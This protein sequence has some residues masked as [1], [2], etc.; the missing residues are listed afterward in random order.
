MKT[1]RESKK[2][3]NLKL[4][5][6]NQEI[7][8]CTFWESTDG[9]SKQYRCGSALFFLCYISFKYKIIIDRMIGAPGHGKNLVDSIN[10]SDKTYLKDKMCMI[11][12]PEVDDCSKRIK[13]HSMID[14]TYYI[15]AEECK[16]LCECIHRE[17]GAKGYSKYNSV[18]LIA[19]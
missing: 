14:N 12:T 10:T 5:L 8:G 1:F 13:A 11:R 17:N 18:K 7:S 3:N 16:R 6:N 19:R 4:K 15:F 9:Y 2:N